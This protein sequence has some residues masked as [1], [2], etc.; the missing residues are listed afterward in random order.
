[1]TRCKE[2]KGRRSMG[3]VF[4]DQSNSVGSVEQGSCLPVT[5]KLFGDFTIT[6]GEVSISNAESRSLKVWLLLAYLLCNRKRTIPQKE[7]SDLLNVNEEADDV[8]ASLRMTRTRVRRLLEPLVKQTGQELMLGRGGSMVWNPAIPTELDAEQFEALCKMAEEKKSK[9]TRV[10]IYC[11][12]LSLYTGNFL[13][14]LSGE[15]WVAPLTAYY[16]ELYL[17]T[18][19]KALPLLQEEGRQEEV[20]RFSREAVRFAPY[21]EYLHVYLMRSLIAVGQY[22]AAED[23]YQSFYQ[24]MMKDLGTV[25]SRELQ[26]L[27]I[28]ALRHMKETAVAPE[29]LLQSLQEE[30]APSGALVCDYGTFRLFYQAEARSASRRGDAVHIGLFSVESKDGGALHRKVLSRTMEQLGQQLRHT[31]RIGD[32]IAACSASQYVV[33]LVQANYED[34]QMVCRRAIRAFQKAH[35]RSL[36][37][38]RSKVIPLEVEFELM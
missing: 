26:E 36:A 21:E 31:L 23:V 4:S 1:M 34:S 12:A 8:S 33:L 30:E 19:E 20:I 22:A 27:H 9:K 32:I 37:V 2:R 16:Q 13:E 28:D 7:L 10:Q 14:K 38:V 18:L 11:K 24:T 6:C 5:V 25:T 17:N 35:P 3:K 15:V 29:R